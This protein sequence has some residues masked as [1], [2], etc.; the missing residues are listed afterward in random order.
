MSFFAD[1]NGNASGEMISNIVS[2]ARALFSKVS[3]K[4]KKMGR[5]KAKGGG[6]LGT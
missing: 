6:L 1:Y 4:A 2:Q 5:G 3:K